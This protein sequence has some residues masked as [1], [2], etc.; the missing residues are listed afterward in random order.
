MKMY[1]G[2][3]ILLHLL[4]MFQMYWAYLHEVCKAHVWMILLNTMRQGVLIA[5]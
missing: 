3:N 4:Q 1:A 2:I 5:S